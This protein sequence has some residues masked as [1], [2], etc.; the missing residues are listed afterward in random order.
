M[1]VRVER[2]AGLMQRSAACTCTQ[3]PAA[4]GSARRVARPSGRAARLGAVGVAARR[5]ARR[6]ILAVS[7]RAALQGRQPPPLPDKI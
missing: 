7:A 5:A 6:P 2:H 4:P 1:K 3:D